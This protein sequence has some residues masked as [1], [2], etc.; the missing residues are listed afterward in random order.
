MINNNLVSQSLQG[1]L[2]GRSSTITLTEINEKAVE[3]LTDKMVGAIVAMD[4]SAAW[5]HQSWN[6]KK[7]TDTHRNKIYICK[8]DNGLFQK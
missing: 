7:E 2:P 5:H 6:F 8:Y 3:I 4:Q 1:G